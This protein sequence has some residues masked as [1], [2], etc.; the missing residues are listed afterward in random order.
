MENSS[1]Y[2]VRVVSI[3]ALAGRADWRHLCY[4]SSYR[5]SIFVFHVLWSFHDGILQM[6]LGTP[7][8]MLVCKLSLTVPLKGLHI[9]MH[10][11]WYIRRKRCW[12]RVHQHLPTSCARR[13]EACRLCFFFPMWFLHPDA[14]SKSQTIIA[15]AH[16]EYPPHFIKSIH[17]TKL[18]STT[19]LR[20]IIHFAQPPGL[21]LVECDLLRQ[22]INHQHLPVST[23]SCCL[24]GE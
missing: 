13:E 10:T 21:S 20:A 5:F 3:Q 16:R 7:Q 24:F 15:G 8:A 4:L 14:F 22:Y 18:D 12:S 23:S 2:I 1:W 19:A 9:M 17:T 6:L 11:G